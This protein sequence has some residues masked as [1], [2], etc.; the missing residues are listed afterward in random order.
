MKRK[1]KD[2]LNEVIDYVIV[3]TIKNKYLIEKE[4]L[5]ILSNKKEVE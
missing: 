5:W 2:I 3:V 1:I 4:D